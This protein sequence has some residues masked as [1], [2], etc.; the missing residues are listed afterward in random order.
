ER[1][2]QAFFRELLLGVETHREVL[3]ELIAAHASRP[4]AQLDPIEHATLLIGVYELRERLETPYR[5]VLNE[6]LELAHEFGGEDGHKF[7]NAI[8][9]KASLTLREAER[10]T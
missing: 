3:D 2:D 6:A 4:L 7:V 9:D 5:V 10:A 8:L 1:V